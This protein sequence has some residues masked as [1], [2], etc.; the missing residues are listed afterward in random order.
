MKNINVNIIL[1]ACII[2]LFPLL[3]LACEDE[4]AGDYTPDQL[5]RP[6]K[7]SSSTSGSSVNFSW[8]PVANS[9]ISLEI[10]KDS[11]AFT[12]ILQIIALDEV[13]EFTVENLYSSTRYSAR[14]KSVSKVI[15]ISDSEYTEITFVT[16]IENI[17]YSAGSEDIT[18]NSINV[19]WNSLKEVSDLIL[20]TNGVDDL[21]INL[22]EGEKAAGEKPIEGLNPGT[23]YN[24]QILN[25]D[26]LRGTIVVTTLS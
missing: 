15:G 23:V 19:K 1:K 3:F 24:I 26:M 9:S 7:F 10:S 16:G 22:S 17:F 11:L 21:I 18:A 8:V 4:N 14:I 25:G 6:V 12:D 5:F 20:S 2:M 13:T